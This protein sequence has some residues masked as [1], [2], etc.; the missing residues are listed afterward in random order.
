M[1]VFVCGVPRLALGIVFAGVVLPPRLNAP[2]VPAMLF[3]S[4]PFRLVAS[5]RFFVDLAV[6]GPGLTDNLGP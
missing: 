6:Y 4:S 2:C 3:S 5:A 1:A